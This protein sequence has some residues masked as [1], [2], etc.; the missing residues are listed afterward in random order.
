LFLIAFRAMELFLPFL[1]LFFFGKS[2]TSNWLRR[3]VVRGVSPA[4][5]LSGCAK[6]GDIFGARFFLSSAGFLLT[7][8]L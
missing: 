5:V 3:A 4:K 6:F 2:Y 7:R 8:A 1:L